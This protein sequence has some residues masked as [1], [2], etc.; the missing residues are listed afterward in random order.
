MFFNNCFVFTIGDIL[1]RVV[2]SILFLIL[3]IIPVSAVGYYSIKLTTDP[4]PSKLNEPFNITV[5]VTG[6]GVPL[7][8]GWVEITR[9]PE[10]TS[11]EV[12]ISGGKIKDG[13]VTISA[14]LEYFQSVGVYGIHARYFSSD[15][16]LSGSV[17]MYHTVSN[18]VTV[19]EFPTI[20]APIAAIICML[21]IF[22]RKK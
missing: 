17:T 8:D 9:F 20:A 6:D 2:L 19:P 14:P 12:V 4:N 13:Y 21:L 7:N 22:E 18:N 1:R 16:F 11:N 5:Y 15:N 10:R 3:L